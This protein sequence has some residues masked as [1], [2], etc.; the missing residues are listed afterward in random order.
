MIPLPGM[1]GIYVRLNCSLRVE[2][3]SYNEETRIAILR[4]KKSLIKDCPYEVG[5]EFPYRIPEE[6]DP[7]GLERLTLE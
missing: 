2:V 5:Q 6:E 3:V 4:A 7:N 1:T